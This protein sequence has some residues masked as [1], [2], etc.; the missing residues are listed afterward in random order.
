MV[1]IFEEPKDIFH[2]QCCEMIIDPFSTRF[3]P[4]KLC[5]SIHVLFQQHHENGESCVSHVD[6]VIPEEEHAS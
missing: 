1:Y 3:D 6:L 5:K 2:D 4:W